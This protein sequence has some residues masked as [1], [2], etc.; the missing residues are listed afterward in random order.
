V[1]ALPDELRLRVHRLRWA[2]DGRSLALTDAERF[3]WCYLPS[4]PD[5]RSSAP[6]RTAAHAPVPS[7]QEQQD[8]NLSDKHTLRRAALASAAA[9]GTRAGDAFRY[10]RLSLAQQQALAI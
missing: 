8:P 2:P 5:E 3:C 10:D 7:G 1:L 9:P 4:Q 6:A